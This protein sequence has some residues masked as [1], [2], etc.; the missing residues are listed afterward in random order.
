VHFDGKDIKIEVFNKGL[1]SLK[2][3]KIQIVL[4]VDPAKV[5]INKVKFLMDDASLKPT[6]YK[7]RLTTFEEMDLKKNL[8]KKTVTAEMVTDLNR[9][10]YLHFWFRVGRVLSGGESYQINILKNNKV[11]HSI[12][13]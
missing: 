9:R 4:F 10:A 5:K 2:N 11:I 6:Q 3:I 7:K 12:K 13:G 1:S 8:A